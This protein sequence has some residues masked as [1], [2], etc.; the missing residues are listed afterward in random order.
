[1]GRR[2]TPCMR[3][4]LA[5]NDTH[6]HDGRTWACLLVATTVVVLVK[7]PIAFAGDQQ[8]T[9]GNVIYGYVPDFDQLRDPPDGLPAGTSF[10]FVPPI[11]IGGFMYCVPTSAINWMAY[12]STHGYP[13]AMDGGA[14]NWASPDLYDEVTDHIAEMGSSAK[15]STDPHTGTHAPGTVVGLRDWLKDR[16]LDDSFTVSRK[17]AHSHFA[18]GLSELS[19]VG[20]SGGLIILNIGWYRL[21]QHQGENVW[22]RKSGHVVTLDGVLCN[23]QGTLH[24]GAKVRFRDPATDYVDACYGDHHSNSPWTSET[25]EI[26]WVTDW[27]VDDGQN[28]QRLCVRIIGFGTTY[29]DYVPFVDGYT[30]IMPQSGLGGGPGGFVLLQPDSLVNDFAV[31][32]QQPY[33]SATGFDIVDMA[34]VPGQWEFFYIVLDDLGNPDPAIWRFNRVTETHDVAFEL[35]NARRLETGRHGEVYVLEGTA[36][37]LVDLSTDPATQTTFPWGLGVDAMV[38]DDETD[39]LYVVSSVEHMALTLSADLQLLDTHP[40]PPGFDLIGEVYVSINPNGGPVWITSQGSDT[41]AA[42]D[43]E[44]GGGMAVQVD[45]ITDPLLLDATSLDV[46]INDHVFVVNNGQVV[47][48]AS[49]GGAWTTVTGTPFAG[50]PV[51]NFFRLA[52]GRTNQDPDDVDTPNLIPTEFGQSVLDCPGDIN[53]DGVVNVADLLLV[54]GAWG[55]NPGHPA[56]FNGDGVVGVIDLLVLLGAWGPCLS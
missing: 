3:R 51:E 22:R 54:L 37:H 16:D 15:M 20:R 50:M 38:Y 23:D 53:G 8:Y 47:E 43:L 7:G 25:Y 13:A 39:R 6:E 49:V 9:I 5:M 1:M 19:S 32:P 27:F 44:G 46:G 42:F 41:A 17:V 24:D 55:P 2:L 36:I 34:I 30:V 29:T 4:D 11:E 45:S 52:R 56:D 28:I 35:P 18:P 33:P 10:C 31:P 26:E 40:L 12:I 48:F 14:Q 21:E